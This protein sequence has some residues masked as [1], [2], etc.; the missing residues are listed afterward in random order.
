MAEPRSD[1]KAMEAAFRRL[2]SDRDLREPDE[3]QPHEDGGIICLWHAEK[4]AVV[5]DPE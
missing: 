4:L 3:I 1:R 5:I 2:L